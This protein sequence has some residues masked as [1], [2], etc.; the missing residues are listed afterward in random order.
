MVPLREIG[1]H[2]ETVKADKLRRVERADFET[3]F[4]VI[5]ASVRPDQL[6]HFEDWTRQFGTPA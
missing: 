4:K 3:A 2:I 6:Q 1:K 5:K